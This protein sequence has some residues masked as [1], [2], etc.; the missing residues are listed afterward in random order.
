MVAPALALAIGS[1][2]GLVSDLIK[3]VMGIFERLIGY[4]IAVH[5][6]LPKYENLTLPQIMQEFMSSEDYRKIEPLIREGEGVSNAVRFVEFLK[7][8]NLDLAKKS[9]QMGIVSPEWGRTTSQLLNAISWSYGFGW[10]SWV[11]LSPILNQVIANRA[12]RELNKLFEPLQITRSQLER[13][14]MAGILT[15]EEFKK[16]LLNRGYSE[17]EAEKYIIYVKNVRME[18]D[19]D[20]T[21]SEIIKAYVEDL[22]SRKDA[23]AMLSSLGYD[24]DEIQILLA[25]A[26]LKKLK[27]KK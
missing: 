12:N 9:L 17:E 8:F 27:A 4:E 6:I 15:E 19:R 7:K 5:V 26:D 20:L 10:L 2:G 18:K 22:I 3:K 13:L 1:A 23:E 24:P 25:L 21:K 14:F 16:E 11:G